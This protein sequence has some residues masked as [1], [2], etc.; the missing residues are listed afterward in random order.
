MMIPAATSLIV[1]NYDGQQ[2]TL[3]FGIFSAFVAAA[4]VIGPVWMGL[5][6]STLSWRWGFAS[7]PVLILLVLYSASLVK[8]NARPVITPFDTVGSVLTFAGLGLIVLGATL[9]GELGW[10]AAK[11]PFM[12]GDLAWA[13]FGLSAALIFLLAGATVLAIY[14]AWAERRRISGFSPL[15]QID[16]LKNRVFSIGTLMGLLFNAAL[17]G[18]LFVLPVFLQSAL[19][20]GALHTGMTLLPYTLGIFIFALGASRLPSTV[21]PFGIVRVGL[22]LML[23]GA[24]WVYFTAGLTLDWGSLIPALF[25]LGAGAG[26]VLS[27]L[28]D[29]ALSTVPADA[30]GEATG[31]NATGKELGGAFGIAVLGSIF[32]TLMYGNVVVHYDAYHNLPEA[33]SEDRQQAIL[34]LE[35]WAAKVTDDEWR[36]FLNSLPQ[37]TGA[38]Y[39]SIVNHAYLSGYQSTVL[40]I[41]ALIALVMGL[42]FFLAQREHRD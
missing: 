39:E 42:S 33:S 19:N 2:R 35:D 4:A 5:V 26:I 23:G 27:R 11:R 17:G 34:K 29:V 40:I 8:E 36:E 10:W 21:S 31:G 12:I 20:L 37:G 3:A 22:A 14:A 38:A 1:L 41:A 7:E 32:M 28:T 30:L 13:P 25:C 6:A 9:A 15:F 24:L 16:L 18:L